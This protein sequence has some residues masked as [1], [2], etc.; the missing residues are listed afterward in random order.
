MTEKVFVSHIGERNNRHVHDLD[1]S[2][3]THQQQHQYY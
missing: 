3:N 2:Q 1:Q